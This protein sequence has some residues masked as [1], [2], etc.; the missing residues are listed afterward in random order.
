MAETGPGERLGRGSLGVRRTAWQHDA[1][2]HLVE[3]S[4]HFVTERLGGVTVVCLASVS[5]LREGATAALAVASGTEVR[6][7]SPR[8]SPGCCKLPS[9][10]DKQTAAH[11]RLPILA[12]SP[13][14]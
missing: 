9:M 10:A 8:I 6:S 14:R 3:P 7:P 13:T 4:A 12:R 11:S 5:Q 1:R 2:E